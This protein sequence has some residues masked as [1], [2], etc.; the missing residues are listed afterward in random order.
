MIEHWSR[1]RFLQPSLSDVIDIAVVTFI[2]YGLFRL[3]SGTRAL[4]VWGGA[5]GQVYWGIEDD[6]SEIWRCPAPLLSWGDRLLVGILCVLFA[7]EPGSVVGLEEVDRGQDLHRKNSV[8]RA[9][10][11]RW[12]FSGWNCTP[13]TLSRATTLA[14]VS[15]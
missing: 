2:I 4:R 10:P 14:K 9:S 12:L 7:A 5:A 3:V 8:R 15:P 1:M 6:R 13:S 11:C